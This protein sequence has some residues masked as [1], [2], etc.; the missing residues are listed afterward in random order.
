MRAG[1]GVEI[2]PLD[3]LADDALVPR[4]SDFDSLAES[5]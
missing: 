2:I 3:Q 1:I 5:G 4:H